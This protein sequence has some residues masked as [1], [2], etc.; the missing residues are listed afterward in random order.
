M[1]SRTGESRSIGQ[2]E[3]AGAG[4]ILGN[5]GVRLLDLTGAFSALAR[6]GLACPPRLLETDPIPLRRVVSSEAASIITDVL[7]DN[8]ARLHSFGRHSALAFPVRVA[9]KTGTSAGFRD[10]WSVGF[11]REHTVGVWV[12]NFD[13][14]PMDNAASIAAAA[15]LWRRAMDD[16]LQADHPVPEPRIQRISIC[17]LSGFR[18]CEQSPA[19]VGELFLPGTEPQTRADD[20]FASDGSL[21]LPNEY[22]AWCASADNHLRATTRPFESELAI[23][24]PRDGA[25]FVIDE[26]LPRAH[27]NSNFRPTSQAVSPGRSMANRSARPRMDESPGRLRRVNGRSRRQTRKRGRPDDLWYAETDLEL[28]ESSLNAV[29]GESRSQACILQAWMLG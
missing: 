7:C 6:G 20:W 13:G 25:V 17:T 11:T 28:F 21:L 24:A 1:R 5:V 16:L 9:A 22:A 4:F 14:A 8:T 26:A 27:S 2:L 3:S 19:T 18:P 12:G 23:L 10:A 15:P 29:T